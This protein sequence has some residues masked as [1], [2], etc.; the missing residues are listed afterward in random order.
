M[1]WYAA[2]AAVRKHKNRNL[3]RLERSRLVERLVLERNLCSG[4]RI[5]VLFFCIFVALTQV[6]P[7]AQRPEQVI[8]LHQA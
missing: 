3:P 4:V 6:T 8:N 7:A 2:Q 1:R 5:I